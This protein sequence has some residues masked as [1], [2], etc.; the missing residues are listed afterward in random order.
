M[1]NK[2]DVSP[3]Q[4]FSFNPSIIMSSQIAEMLGSLN[5]G[6]SAAQRRCGAL[7]ELGDCPRN[8]DRSAEDR[9]Y[10]ATSELCIA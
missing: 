4:M 1:R 8:L 9:H 3:A 2:L 6:R 10:S 7:G 5:E